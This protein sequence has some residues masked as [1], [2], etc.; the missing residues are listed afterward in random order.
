MCSMRI[1]YVG[2][3]MN[4]GEMIVKGNAG[5]Y[6]GCQMSSGDIT[7]EGSADFGTGAEMT[8][9]KIQ[10]QGDSG[11]LVGGA[12]PGSHYGMN[13]GTIL[14]DGSVGNGCGFRMRRGFIAV[15]KNAGQ[16]VGHQML[17]GT[18][19]FGSCETDSFGPGVG[20]KRGTLVCL[21]PMNPAGRFKF[22][23]LS[24][25]TVLNL[26]Q[27]QA[28]QAGCELDEHL[29]GSSKFQNFSG[30]YT[31]EGKGELFVLAP[32]VLAPEQ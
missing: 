32:E 3:R 25:P 29:V 5:C 18:I 23:C 14:V 9:G 22:N 16:S 21:S 20:M 8:G 28:K 27:Q 17:A 7:V 12:L 11:D 6:V 24:E 19:V 13:G 1:H 30:D 4:G 2:Y 10:I 31:L 15:T 26:L